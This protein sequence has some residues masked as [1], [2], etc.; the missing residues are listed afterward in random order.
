M[1]LFTLWPSLRSAGTWPISG[2]VTTE[3]EWG[4]SVAGLASWYIPIIQC[5]VDQFYKHVLEQTP[6]LFACAAPTCCSV[7]DRLTRR[8]DGSLFYS[9]YP[10][11]HGSCKF[12][13]SLGSWPTASEDRGGKKTAFESSFSVTCW[14]DDLGARIVIWIVVCDLNCY[15]MACRLLLCVVN[16]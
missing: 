15:I 12:C 10:S 16:C 3:K 4:A 7:L 6:F 5:A 13:S 11:G 1:C 9:C 8:A 2:L 14:L